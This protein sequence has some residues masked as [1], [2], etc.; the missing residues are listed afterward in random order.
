MLLNAA[1]QS[2]Q[3]SIQGAPQTTQPTVVAEFAD[4][5]T[6][7]FT[8]APQL[9]T[10]NGS[11]P[12]QV[13]DPPSGSTQRKIKEL[14]IANVDTQANTF[15]V[16]FVDGAGRRQVV[17][18]EVQPGKVLMYIDGYGW[19]NGFLQQGPQGPA[20][21][22]GASYTHTQLSASAIWTVNHNLG[23][24]PDITLYS[25]GGVVIDGFV[26]HINN[27]QA[28]VDLDTATTG[29]ARCE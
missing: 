9:S 7:T 5:T 21:P 19:T 1:T 10:L 18:E 23:F 24:R 22:A 8:P 13:V 27:N 14:V 16:E 15:L 2:V 4:I 3:V 6:T 28:Q 12:V 11:T 17:K 20:G 25:S 29:T 26:T